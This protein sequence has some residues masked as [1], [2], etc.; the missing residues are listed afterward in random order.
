MS[1]FR[2]VNNSTNAGSRSRLIGE[3]I[4]LL[5]MSFILG[6]VYYE[7][8]CFETGKNPYIPLDIDDPTNAQVWVVIRKKYFIIKI[9][10]LV[11]FVYI[12]HI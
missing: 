10:I 12:I 4:V 8:D 6:F 2:Q 9:T 5:M 1:W 7:G 3:F 11:S